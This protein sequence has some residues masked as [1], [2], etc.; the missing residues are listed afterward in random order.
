MLEEGKVPLKDQPE[1]LNKLGKL[2]RQLKTI[3]DS[4]RIDNC[5]KDLTDE[6]YGGGNA[7]VFR[8]EYQGR[9]VAVKSLRLYLTSDFE[10]CFSVSAKPSLV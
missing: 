7:T 9:P 1:F 4:M 3:P 2:C 8:S 5:L 10:E 6:E